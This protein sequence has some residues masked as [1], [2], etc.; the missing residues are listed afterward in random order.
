MTTAQRNNEGPWENIDWF[1]S[2]IITHGFKRSFCFFHLLFMVT[3]FCYI[4]A[5]NSQSK[6]KL[7][8]TKATT[9]QE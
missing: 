3:V 8:Q 7:N 1:I 4:P 6:K 5:D 9:Q 2:G